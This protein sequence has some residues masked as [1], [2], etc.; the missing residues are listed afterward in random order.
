MNKMLGA[1]SGVWLAGMACAE[2]KVVSAGPTVDGVLDGVCW[3][4]ASWQSDFQAK[5]LLNRGQVQV[6]E[7]EV[8]E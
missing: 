6:H 1:M 4:K 8:L 5:L 3:T 7:L 2:V